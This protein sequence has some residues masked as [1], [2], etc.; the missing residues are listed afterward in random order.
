M[1]MMKNEE[2]KEQQP[3]VWGE[4][5]DDIVTAFKLNKLTLSNQEVRL[6]SRLLKKHES[7]W[8]KKKQGKTN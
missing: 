7:V 4:E 6:L 1:T 8:S 3:D 5:I 2:T